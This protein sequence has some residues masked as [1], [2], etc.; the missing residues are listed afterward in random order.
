MDI[1]QAQHNN[2]SVALCYYQTTNPLIE[3]S[4][5][6]YKFSTQHNICLSWV[7]ELDAP[8]IL[9]K[10]GGCCGGKKSVFRVATETEVRRWSGT[11]ER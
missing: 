6:A 1:S 9:A 3:V 10:K 11:S 7:S 8:V 2:G 5:R 4:G